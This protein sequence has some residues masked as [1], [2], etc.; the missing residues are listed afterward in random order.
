MLSA[1]GRRFINN[2][3]DVVWFSPGLAVLNSVLR[4]LVWIPH[5]VYITSFI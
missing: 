5:Y 3:P 4:V 2:R 1:V